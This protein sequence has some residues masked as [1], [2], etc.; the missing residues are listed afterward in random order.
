MRFILQGVFFFY[1]K[2]YSPSFSFTVHKEPIHYVLCMT[3]CMKIVWYLYYFKQ[4]AN[5][6]QSL[7]WHLFY[8]IRIYLYVYP[9][10][11]TIL[12]KRNFEIIHALYIVL[13]FIFIY[14]KIYQAVPA[15]SYELLFLTM[16]ICYNKT[17]IPRGY[18]IF[19][20]AHIKIFVIHDLN[21][22]LPGIISWNGKWLA[23]KKY[24]M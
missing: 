10:I 17:L 7:I 18:K 2:K 6:N 22:H 5:F 9:I 4:L 14:K 13:I 19:K 8:N 16:I 24:E 15:F 11:R 12:K 3:K 1:Y 21:Y 23:F 20:K